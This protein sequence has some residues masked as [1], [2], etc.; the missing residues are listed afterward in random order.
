V[1]RRLLA[2]L[3]VAASAATLT[4]NAFATRSVPTANGGSWDIEDSSQGSS[5]SG[6]SINGGIDGFGG[7][8]LNVRGPAGVLA[9]NT[10]VEELGLTYDGVDQF[11]TTQSPRIGGIAVQRT[12]TVLRGANA[13]R[14]ADT[15]F[16]TTKE[17]RTVRVSWGGSLGSDG[18]PGWGR[19]AASTDGDRT[20]EATDS[21]VTWMTDA[22]NALA[23][24]STGPSSKAPLAQVTG[25]LAKDGLGDTEY[26]PFADAYPG[27]LASFI[28]YR[29]RLELAPG[30]AAT[31]VTFMTK[32]LPETGTRAPGSQIALVNSAAQSLAATPDFS[33]L[34]TGIRCSV[35]NWA[36]PAS[37]C[38]AATDPGR[39]PAAIPAQPSR[40]TSTYPVVGK[41][42]AQLQADLRAGVTTSEELVKAYMDRIAAYDRSGPH[43]DSFISVSPVALAEARA[44]D[45][46]RKAGEDLGPLM[47][48][49]YG[50]KDNIDVLGLTSQNGS[51]ALEGFLPVRDTW[52]IARLRAAGAIAIGKTNLDEWASSGIRSQT[53]MG[54]LVRNPYAT[55]R[56]SGGSSGG[57]GVATAASLAAFTMGTDN[58]SSTRH[59]S[60][61]NSAVTMLPTRELSPNRGIMGSANQN[62]I[63]PIT[64]SA[65]DLALILDVI[66]GDSPE[67]EKT[68][69]AEA[70]RPPSYPALLDKGALAGARIGWVTEAWTRGLHTGCAA[71]AEEQGP[72]QR[73]LFD[74]ALAKL[75][76]AGATVVEVHQ[77]QSVCDRWG[78]QG[79]TDAG[80]VSRYLNEQYV[81]G[82]P[83]FPF[84]TYS[85]ARRS[86]LNNSPSTSTLG[87]PTRA[88]YEADLAENLA[89]RRAY[90]ADIQ[91]Y[92][93]AAGVDVLIMPRN[94]ADIPY[95]DAQQWNGRTFVAP[96]SVGGMPEMVVPAGFTPQGLPFGVSF[97][98]RGFADAKV[99]SI[100]YATE[101]L[102][103]A[104]REPAST[105][106]LELAAKPGTEAQLPAPL[107]VPAAP[108][109]TAAAPCEDALAP[110]L[111][112]LTR[113]FAGRSG[114]RIKAGRG[115]LTLA[116]SATDRG[117]QQGRA[118]AAGE[119][120]AVEVA[121][122]RVDGS[123]C[124]PL[125]R[126]GKVGARASCSAPR[127]AAATLSGAGSAKR[128]TLRFTSTTLKAGSYRMLFR[129]RDRAGNV[130]ATRTL[131]LRV[132]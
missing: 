23:D 94:K 17:P 105:P 111:S 88:V 11:T 85:E 83:A 64:R 57:S 34:S 100:A 110:S 112:V 67:D 4:P 119:P 81:L 32:G 18:T 78:A 97:I 47:G 92:M 14:Y 26:D 63:A 116:G 21:W 53:G 77:P 10:L 113:T 1:T 25:T 7:L 115:T 73:K 118:F 33:G 66:V 61:H 62:H 40:T 2:G 27:R 107:P 70:L 106:E 89:Q 122:A 98:G 90:R 9:A 79:P 52:Q 129:A 12:V 60:G 82:Q 101:Q 45:A 56:A 93:D 49:P 38:E 54:G 24:P 68:D 109:P 130:S 41:S 120:V 42:I 36:P 123:R 59:P 91:A 20:P 117:C 44:M 43:L 74:A 16:N 30:K 96:G 124:R 72:E 95:N 65:E 55:D 132:R 127:F 39:P 29:Y 69:G 104:R 37:G 3:I 50:V 13:V 126:S 28:G 75:T 31:L 35:A 80:T 5:G 15:L 8:R 84:A 102:L 22:S 131:T 121:V 6:I 108:V 87:P 19:V 46:R 76:G 128:W 51:L 58:Y 103:A 48:I 114:T 125:S 86:P 99:F 71:A